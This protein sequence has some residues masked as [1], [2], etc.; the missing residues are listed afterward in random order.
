MLRQCSLLLAV[1]AALGSGGAAIAHPEDPPTIH[2]AFV[3]LKGAYEPSERIRGAVEVEADGPLAHGRL[4]VVIFDSDRCDTP[5]GC[6]SVLVRRSRGVEFDQAGAMS[7]R[8]GV[9]GG[10]GA[11]SAY[12]AVATLTVGPDTRL[13]TSEVGIE[14]SGHDRTVIATAVTGFGIRQPELAAVP[15]QIRKAEIASLDVDAV[16]AALAEAAETGEPTDLPL[17]PGLSVR[18]RVQAREILGAGVEIPGLGRPISYVGEL[19]DEQGEVEPESFVSLLV[20]DG[21]LG[22]HVRKATSASSDTAFENMIVDALGNYDDHAPSDQH[23]V[24]RGRNVLFEPGSHPEPVTSAGSLAP[25]SLD[26]A[27]EASARETA[28]ALAG[29][30]ASVEATPTRYFALPFYIYEHEGDANTRQR[31]QIVNEVLAIFEREFARIV[32][33]EEDFHEITVLEP[34]IADWDDDLSAEGFAI[35]ACDA[36]GKLISNVPTKGGAPEG[37]RVLF[38]RLLV[39]N[40]DGCARTGGPGVQAA[41]TVR[42]TSSWGGVVVMLQEVGHNLDF[43]NSW[44]PKP[45]DEHTD[46][47]VVVAFP[48]LAP[49]FLP[50][51]VIPTG[52]STCTAMGAGSFIPWALGYCIAPQPSYSMGLLRR[53]LHHLARGFRGHL[54]AESPVLTTVTGLP[55][56]ILAQDLAVD[57]GSGDVWLTAT[58]TRILKKAADSD[59][60]QQE[61]EPA[62][63]DR[64]AIDGAGRPWVVNRDGEVWQ[65]RSAEIGSGWDRRGGVGVA[66]DIGVGGPDGQ[67]VWIIGTQPAFDGGFEILKYNEADGTWKTAFGAGLRVSVDSEGKPWVV[68]SVGQLWRKG[69][70]DPLLDDYDLIAAPEG[71]IDV[72]I[73]TEVTTFAGSQ[74]LADA[75]VIATAE[76]AYFSVDFGGGRK[77]PTKPSWLPVFA[78]LVAGGP[79]VPFLDP[80]PPTGI[81][82]GYE[83]RPE[84][85]GSLWR[86]RPWIATPHAIRRGEPAEV[87]ELPPCEP[88]DC[89]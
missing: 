50:P 64:I 78:E 63:A 12:T 4:E 70:D 23:L 89:D 17:A 2:L 13:D 31:L 39:G 21:Q 37:P 19:V 85:R 3:G 46:P 47:Q 68:N 32:P 52:L 82:A 38:S 26:A 10:L 36:V 71:V 14:H 27:L 66:S 48:I 87:E 45:H 84:S 57:R 62:G 6:P 33:D 81:A 72:A 43:H 20:V 56:G 77:L 75:T 8:F 25:T 55:P 80:S 28:S 11:V 29:A 7:L 16:G 30:L 67:G 65:K 83:R 42:D 15:E 49:F 76:R 54:V 61:P 86:V 40:A 34:H 69:S 44:T 22:G 53:P 9:R 5:E 35:G 51:F 24:Y 41:S 58:N 74:V 60:W 18:A 59:L 1:L 79:V 73:G 88:P